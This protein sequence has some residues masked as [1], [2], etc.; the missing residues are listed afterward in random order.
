[1]RSAMSPK[2]QNIKPVTASMV[3]LIFRCPVNQTLIFETF[4]DLCPKVPQ[5]KGCF[6][7]QLG[8]DNRYF[9]NSNS[10]FEE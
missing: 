1:M 2:E 6:K 9:K 8:L 10:E 5:P 4:F 3:F 7:W